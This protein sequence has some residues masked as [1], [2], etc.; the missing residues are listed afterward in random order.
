MTSRESR[1]ETQK[2]Q[3][4][5]LVKEVAQHLKNGG[6]GIVPNFPGDMTAAAIGKVFESAKELLKREA[7]SV[8]AERQ[9]KKDDFRRSLMEWLNCQFC[10]ERM[11]RTHD[12]YAE[13]K[14]LPNCKAYQTH[15]KTQADNE[16]KKRLYTTKFQ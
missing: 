9:E 2:K 7:I 6:R 8:E 3:Y 16:G 1:E 11:G 5:N 4:G 15:I 13:D 14:H 10:G 12:L